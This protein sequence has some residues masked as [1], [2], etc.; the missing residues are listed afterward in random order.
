M[1]LPDADKKSPRVYT[2]SQNTDLENLAFAT[3][4][5]IGNP[6]NI[7]ELNEDELRRLVLVNL[8][9]LSVK[10]EW[11]GLLSAGG[12]GGGGGNVAAPVAT[13]LDASGTD[14]DRFV[15]AKQG[16]NGVVNHVWS[17]P[18][19]CYCAFI[20]PKSGAVAEVG[21]N[22]TATGPVVANIGIYSN[23]SDNTPK[24]LLGQADIDVEGSGTGEA[25]QTS[26]SST[27]T[28]VK[29]TQYWIAIC[30]EAAT[31]FNLYVLN[32]YY[33]ATIAPEDGVS[34]NNYLGTFLMSV[35]NLTAL[36]SSPVA[37]ELEPNGTGDYMPLIS[38]KF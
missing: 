29:G 14:Y 5:S 12:G 18:Q 2:L 6:I 30:R 35:A 21:I 36:P 32:H 22:I 34:G 8:A 33:N 28:L 3:M 24:T 1:P 7:E 20:A 13:E 38:I 31:S 4:Q 16:S 27:I 23:N 25:Y 37:A 9:R 11:D 26:F 10:G 19:V 17:N 15:V